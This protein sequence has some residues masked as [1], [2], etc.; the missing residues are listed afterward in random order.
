[1]SSSEKSGSSISMN[2]L[3]QRKN[4]PD[5]YIISKKENPKF[6]LI[7]PEPKSNI[8]LQD[9]SNNNTKIHER[10]RIN[11]CFIYDS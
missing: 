8:S 9:K 11:S 6:Y 10:N 7:K 5:V 4:N 3:S 1:M 2:K